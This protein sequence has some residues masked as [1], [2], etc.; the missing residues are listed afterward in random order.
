MEE[1]HNF[2]EPIH[3]LMD[4]VKKDILSKKANKG[5]NSHNKDIINLLFNLLDYQITLMNQILMFN[6]TNKDNIIDNQKNIDYLIRI[7]KDILVSMIN[8]FVI[9]INALFNRISESE[10][11]KQILN[12]RAKNPFDHGKILTQNS[13]IDNNKNNFLTVDSF[14]KYNSPIKKNMEKEFNSAI[15]LTQQSSAKKILSFID[16]DKNSYKFLR[17]KN[18]MFSIKN[19]PNNDVYDKLYYNKDQRCNHE[20]KRRNKI[21]QYQAYSKSMK[22]IF[23]DLNDDNSKKI[24]N[25][26]IRTN[27]FKGKKRIR[28]NDL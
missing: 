24:F 5:A 13:T 4:A 9:N 11:K 17:N 7:N 26:S 21:M 14:T 22:D 28:D 23:V 19:K 25:K 18:L 3:I 15:S 2:S 10:S 1:I 8:K 20:E 12:N 6:K 27:T 16:P